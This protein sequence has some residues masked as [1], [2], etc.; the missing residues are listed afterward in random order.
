MR[1]L[2]HMGYGFSL[3][4]GAMRSAVWLLK[5]WIDNS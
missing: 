4:Y 5:R 3:G 1:L 2:L